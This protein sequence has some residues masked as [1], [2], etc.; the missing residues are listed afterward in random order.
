MTNIKQIENI[1]KKNNRS[2]N[3]IIIDNIVINKKE[4]EKEI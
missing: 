2:I 3:E 4:A 1:K